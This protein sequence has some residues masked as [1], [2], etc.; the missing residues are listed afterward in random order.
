MAR[1]A[2]TMTAN[3]EYSAV[4]F[5]IMGSRVWIKIDTHED[6]NTVSSLDSPVKVPRLAAELVHPDLW[7][8]FANHLKPSVDHATLF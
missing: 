6:G 7:P 5:G 8:A 3:L 4:T 2:F 1:R